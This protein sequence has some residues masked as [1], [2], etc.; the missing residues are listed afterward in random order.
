M[1]INAKFYFAA[2]TFMIMIQVIRFSFPAEGFLLHLTV[3]RLIE[4]WKGMRSGFQGLVGLL[5]NHWDWGDCNL[6]TNQYHDEEFQRF[7]VT[8]YRPDSAL[9][10][11]I[12]GI[13]LVLTWIY[14]IASHQYQD[15]KRLKERR[16]PVLSGT[17]FFEGFNKNQL[18]ARPHTGVGNPRWKI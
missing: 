6:V 9:I 5:L 2:S 11:F 10:Q 12:L 1:V 13:R 7:N 17:L 15:I 18:Y 8:Y 3:A 16:L 4:N 14:N